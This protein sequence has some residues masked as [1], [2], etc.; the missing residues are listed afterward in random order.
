MEAIRAEPCLVVDAARSAGLALHEA[1]EVW[2]YGAQEGK[3]RLHD[4][5][6][7]ERWIEEVT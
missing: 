3:L 5:G 1:A 6:H 7:G 4:K 2:A